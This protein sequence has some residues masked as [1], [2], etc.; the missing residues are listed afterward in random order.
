MPENAIGITNYF[1]TASENNCEGP[2]AQIEIEIEE[3]GIV[4]PTAFTPDGD[5]TN[6]L[7]EIENID[8]VYPKNKVF[9]YNRWGNLIYESIEGI[10]NQMKWDGSYNGEKLPVGTYYFIIEYNDNFTASSNGI[11][12]I[13]K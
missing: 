7:W 4:I 1:V 5:N 11:V 10:Y 8:V 3:C 2:F 12:S 13:I 9:V 6:D